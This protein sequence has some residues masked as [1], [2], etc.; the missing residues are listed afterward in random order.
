MDNCGITEL[1]L[2]PA[3]ALLSFNRIA[4]LANAE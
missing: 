2:E 1:A 4:H 3:P